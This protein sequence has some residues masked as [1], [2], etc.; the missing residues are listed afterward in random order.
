MTALPDQQWAFALIL[1][2]G[3]RFW[4]TAPWILVL[5]GCLFL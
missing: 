1:F 3:L 2:A 5:I 4:E